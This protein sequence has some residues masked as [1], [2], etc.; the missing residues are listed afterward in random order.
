[1]VRESSPPV[2]VAAAPAPVRTIDSVILDVRDAPDPGAE[3]AALHRLHDWLSDHQMTYR[4]G[5][6]DGTGHPVQ[7][8]TLARF[9][10]TVSVSIYQQTQPVRDF[11]FVAKDNRNLAIIGVQ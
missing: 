7:A 8:A 4:V 2:V 11:S 1:V 9:P 6:V 5:A 10:V 3:A